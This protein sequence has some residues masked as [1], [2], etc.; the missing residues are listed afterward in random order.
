MKQIC[1]LFFCILGLFSISA[2]KH[3]HFKADFSIKEKSSKSDVY[4]LVVGSV[5]YDALSNKTQYQIIFPQK[6]R[7]IIQDS[8]LTKYTH[9]TLISTVK[10][11]NLNEYFFFDN[12]VNYK[13]NDFGLTDLGFET[14]DVKIILDTIHLT[15]SPPHQYKSFIKEATTRLKDNV[16]IAVSFMDVS[17]MEIHKIYYEDY[18]FINDM[19]VPQKVQ[20]L[21]RTS[22]E[23]LYKIITFRSLELR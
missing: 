10:I 16:L 15:W 6:Q 12:I 1:V 13:G 4:K 9:D 19:P 5:D 7:W 14:I 2:Q 23:E 17:G 21:Y 11:G 18:I 20:T 8:F 3:T 22:K